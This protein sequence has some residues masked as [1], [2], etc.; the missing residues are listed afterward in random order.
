MKDM[1]TNMN[2]TDDNM[3][4]WFLKS[5]NATSMRI[6]YIDGLNKCKYCL[7]FYVLPTIILFRK[8]TNGEVCV[9]TDGKFHRINE[10]DS[11]NSY[12][13]VPEGFRYG[14]YVNINGVL[15]YRDNFWDYKNVP[16]KNNSIPY[17]MKLR[18]ML[19]IEY[20]LVNS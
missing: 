8:N 10:H 13:N 4:P 7:E 20:H 17:M 16:Y 18:P 1:Q 12:H 15:M 6:I 2:C 5:L 19:A 11:L 14:A 3:S 9:L